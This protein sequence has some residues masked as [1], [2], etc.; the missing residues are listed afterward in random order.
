M[1]AGLHKTNHSNINSSSGIGGVSKKTPIIFDIRIAS[2]YG[3]VKFMSGSALDAEPTVLRGDIVFS[4]PEV[5]HVKRITL[6]LVGKFKLEFLQ[7]G[8]HK[9]NNLASIVK[10]DQTI[11]EAFW[12][13]LL[14]DK[15]GVV[16]KGSNASG[17]GTASTGSGSGNSSS[18]SSLSSKP[19]LSRVRSVPIMNNPAKMKLSKAS[20]PAVLKLPSNGVSGTP[21]NGTNAPTGASFMLPPGNYELPFQIVFPDDMP[22]TVEGLQS[23]SVLYTMESCIERHGFNKANFTK[24]EYLRIFRTLKPDNLAIQEEV[25]VGKS[26]PDKLQYEISIPSKAIP[27]GGA[28]PLTVKLYPFQKGYKLKKIVVS[29]LQYYEFKDSAGEVYDDENVIQKQM[30][31]KFDDLPGCDSTQDN[32]L[33]DQIKLNSVLQFPDDLKRATQDCDVGAD[34]IKVRHKLQVHITLKRNVIHKDKPDDPPYEQSTEIKVNLP[35]K[36]Y[37]M[38]HVPIQ[39]RLVLLDHF[40]KIHFRPGQ[41][42]P[43]FDQ[44]DESN[45]GT[46]PAEPADITGINSSSNDNN[47]NLNTTAPGVHG[48]RGG[49]T[50]LEDGS[51]SVQYF[52]ET[53]IQA[54]PSYEA[55]QRESTPVQMTRSLPT[56]PPQQLDDILSRDQPSS[57]SYFDGPPP[58][59]RLQAPQPNNNSVALNALLNTSGDAGNLQ[60][61]SR[62]SSSNRLAALAAAAAGVAGNTTSGNGTNSG[63]SAAGALGVSSNASSNAA[64]MTD[65]L[66]HLQRLPS[67]EESRVRYE[68]VSREPTPLYIPSQ[69]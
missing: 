31:A 4:L 52:P 12:H 67:Y 45:G 28:T 34:L 25:T 64:S 27:I 15:E 2:K 26:W 55:Y 1:F 30:L 62:N 22:E 6:R 17:T 53:D 49:V 61:Q 37:L 43:L 9:N 36:L 69:Q 10:E 24:Y 13:N 7:V 11:F 21:Y 14:V 51:F 32:L 40:G 50:R 44:S 68:N 60:R 20:S 57:P 8:Q 54:P 35:I 5:L 29:L 33:I 46:S 3:N 23:G 58:S 42:C 65:L 48:N 38:E 39:G 19:I 56:T 63:S 41:F 47:A 18:S 66:S 16:L 59:W